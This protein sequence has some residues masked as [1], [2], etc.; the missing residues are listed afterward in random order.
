[1]IYIIGDSFSEDIQKKDRTKYIDRYFEYKGRDI[2]L[3]HDLLSDHF[4]KPITNLSKGG[5][6]NESILVEFM[7]IYPLLK[8]N[9][10]IVLG[11][12]DITRFPTVTYDNRWSSSIHGDSLLSKQALDEVKVMR[13]HDLF[14]KR[15]LD[16]LDF[17]DILI[18]KDITI[19]HWTWTPNGPWLNPYTI[20]YETNGEIDDNHYSELGHIYLFDKMIK[21]LEV[22]NR[23]RINL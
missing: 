19:I 23:V 14:K 9:D 3:Y 17:I 2:K 22:T 20:K 1:M 5:T 12:T 8:S 21:E 13:T 10:V 18:P 11:W 6:C 7:K 15:L 16:I 4:N